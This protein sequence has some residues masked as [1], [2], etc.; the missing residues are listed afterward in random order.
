MTH[1]ARRI[2]LPFTALVGQD[3]LKKALLLNAINPTLCG[4]LIRGEKGTAKSTSVRSLAE[5]LPE[6]DVVKCCFQCS[7]TTP[8]LQCD[9]CH[10]KYHAG[11]KLEDHQ[12]QGHAPE[13]PGAGQRQVALRHR[14]RMDVEDQAVERGPQPVA[15][16]PG[17][18]RPPENGIVD[19]R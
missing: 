13:P 4:V 11:E 15:V 17:V 14:R 6:I 19:S 12:H 1:Q 3:T 5:L 16:A 9:N 10:A 8:S 18:Q 2:V 7:P